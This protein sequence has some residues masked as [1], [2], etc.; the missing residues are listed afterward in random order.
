M[1]QRTLVIAGL[2]AVGVAI[3]VAVPMAILALQGSHDLKFE[4]VKSGG[5]AG[6]NEKLAFDS[7][8]SFDSKTNIITFYKGAL[9]ATQKQLSDAKIQEIRETI[10]GSGFFSMGSIPPK[11]GPADYFSYSLTVTTEGVTHSVLWVDDFA[12]SEP[13]PEGLKNIVSMI[14]EAYSTAS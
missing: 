6:V 11:A 7:K 13:V 14:E 3:A 1:S 8:A 5:I 12:S 4:Y 9:G 2:A 10:A